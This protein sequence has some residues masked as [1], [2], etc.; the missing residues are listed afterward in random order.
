MR[1]TK[2]D[3]ET[4][5]LALNL[6]IRD[7]EAGINPEIPD[8]DLEAELRKEIERFTKLRDKISISLATP[9]NR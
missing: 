1:L 4:L 6:A 3:K 2:T 9:F 8:A 7:K 5:V